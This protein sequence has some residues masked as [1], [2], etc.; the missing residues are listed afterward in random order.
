MA[1]EKIASTE[2]LTN[3]FTKTLFIRVFDRHR[4][5]LGVKCV[6]RML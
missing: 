6:P 2:N 1:I 3:P 4:D 5:S